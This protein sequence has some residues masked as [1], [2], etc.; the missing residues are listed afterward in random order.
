MWSGI[1]AL[2]SRVRF[3]LVRSRVDDEVRQE[4]EMHLELLIERYVRSGMTEDDARRAARRQLGNPL[5]V[6]EEI[7]HMNSLGWLEELAADVRFA[8]RQL[9]RAPAFTV[10]AAVTL[11]LGIG[12][13]TAMFALADAALLRPLPFANPDRLVLVEER[14][15]QETGGAGSNC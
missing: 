11:A 9:R 7:Y 10:V 14:G 3:A 13:N 4:F 8:L 2:A 1:V 12:V 6:R 15:P 5:L